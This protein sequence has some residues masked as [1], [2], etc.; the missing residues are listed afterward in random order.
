[1]I[2]YISASLLIPFISIAIYVLYYMFLKNKI[3][4]LKEKEAKKI[5]VLINI[6]VFAFGFELIGTNVDI[7]E[8]M[9][10]YFYPI[11]ILV[12]PKILEYIRCKSNKQII[13]TI[14][15]MFSLLLFLNTMRNNGGEILPY[16]TL[17]SEVL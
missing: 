13:L 10:H 3:N 9:S 2:N 15:V 17:F 4:N 14:L 8:R 7:V 11:V 5:N 16:R 1:M 12:L 6:L